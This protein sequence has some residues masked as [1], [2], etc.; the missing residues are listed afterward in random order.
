MYV[1]YPG[2]KKEHTWAKRQA[3]LCGRRR[4]NTYLALNH[5]I[6]TLHLFPLTL[7]GIGRIEYPRFRCRTV[8]RGWGPLMAF[9]IFRTQVVCSSQTNRD[10]RGYE[11]NEDSRE[12]RRGQ[13]EE[14]RDGEQEQSENRYSRPSHGRTPAIRRRARTRAR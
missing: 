6:M 13:N 10:T 4:R 7:H 1:Q 11:I 12:C 5:L 8:G 2:K 3:L 14:M 9:R